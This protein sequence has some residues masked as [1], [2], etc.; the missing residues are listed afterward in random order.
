MSQLHTS[1]CE[2]DLREET[3]FE[4]KLRDKEKAAR[5]IW[6]GRVQGSCC[7]GVGAEQEAEGSERV[8]EAGLSIFIPRGSQ[9]SDCCAENAVK[10]H[11]MNPGVAKVTPR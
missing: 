8:T 10:G 6:A 2:R 9:L 5:L 3:L 4:Q 1:G 7:I 11:G